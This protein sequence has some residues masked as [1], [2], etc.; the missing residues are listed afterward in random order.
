MY[1]KTRGEA[2]G[3]HSI[4]TEHQVSVLWP[5]LFSKEESFRH[6]S[7]DSCSRRKW[8]IKLELNGLHMRRVEVARDC[9]QKNLAD[10]SLSETV[11]E[12]K[13]VC[14]SIHCSFFFSFLLKNLHFL[15]CHYFLLHMLYVTTRFVISS[16]LILAFLLGL[17]PSALIFLTFLLGSVLSVDALLGHTPRTRPP[18][19][20]CPFC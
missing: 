18:P 13:D 12:E 11:L 17:V 1:G 4:G 8:E 9:I 3:M 2:E 7:T 15:L 6:R 14:L 19:G 10:A 5:F 16:L 20:T